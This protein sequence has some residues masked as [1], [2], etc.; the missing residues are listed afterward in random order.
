MLRPV[1]EIALV[2]NLM[3]S[4]EENSAA[5]QALS[6]KSA[7]LWRLVQASTSSLRGSLV[8]S[9]TNSEVSR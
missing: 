5:T 4:A 7:D 3:E 9:V 2:L 8:S 6:E 1:S